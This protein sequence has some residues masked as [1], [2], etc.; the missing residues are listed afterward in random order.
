MKQTYKRDSALISL[1]SCS[2]EMTQAEKNLGIGIIEA[3]MAVQEQKNIDGI[4]NR[5]YD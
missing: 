5:Y 4:R 2:E 1:I 3:R